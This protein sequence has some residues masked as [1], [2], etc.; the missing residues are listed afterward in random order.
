MIELTKQQMQ[1]FDGLM[2][3]DAYLRKNKGENGNGRF[4]L[5]TS[6]KEFAEKVMQIF[7]NFPW[8]EKSLIT[9]DRYD[10]R[11]EKSHSSTVLVSLSDSFF[12]SQ[13]YRWYPYGKKIVPKDI[14]ITKDMLLWWYIGDGH[15]RR[16]KG[17]PN[18]RNVGLATMSFS[19][20]EVDILI[21]KLKLFIGDNSIYKDN[22]NCIYIASQSLCSFAELF[23]DGSPIGCYGYKFEFGQYLNKNYW[24]DSFKTRPINYINEFRK[25]N[26]VREL[27]F[28]SKSDIRKVSSLYE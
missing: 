24:E 2:I 4:C 26:K 11:T 5:T 3:S 19:N 27:D 8:S 6:K 25:K 20:D 18:Y 17:R 22:R 13:Y 23:K 21:R 12:T 1:I 7:S 28:R 10:K 14:E 9:F 16:K 15:L